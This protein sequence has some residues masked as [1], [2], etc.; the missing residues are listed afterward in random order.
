M[1]IAAVG[2]HVLDTHVIGIDSIPAGSDGQLVEQIRFSPA[3]TAGGTAVVL[4]RL[5]AEVASYG[6]VG[7]DPIASVLLDLLAAEGVSV[8]GLVR[9]DDHQTSSSVIPVRPNGDRPAWHCI[10][11][12]GAFTLDDL[13]ADALEGVTHLHL[14][15]PEFL[16]G[17]AAGELLARA[18]SLGIVTSLDVLAPGDPDMLAWIRDALP[19]TDYLLPNDEQ[20]LGFTGA[21]SLVDGARALVEAGAGCVAATAGAR[22][23]VVVTAD[24]VVEVPAYDVPVVDTTGCGDAF[25]AG[26]LRGLALGRDLRG[27][28][29]LGCA[30]AG[31]VAA[32]LGTD[33]G[34]YS[35]DSVLAVVAAGVTRQ[36]S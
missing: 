22:G 6:A 2:V 20:V 15:G 12:N 36:L 33:A 17:P 11:A 35:L 13:P 21:S 7:T 34:S 31:Q 28:A 16:G 30:T 26:F 1:K 27:A 18:R 14:G 5:G 3:G 25:S 8:A 32:G 24:S 29:E 10:G 23:A 4:A 19:H 9:K